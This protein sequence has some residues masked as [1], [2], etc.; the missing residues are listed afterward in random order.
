MRNY[1]I[2]TSIMVCPAKHHKAAHEHHTAGHDE[3][4]AHEAHAARGHQ[5]HAHAAKKHSKKYP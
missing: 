3:K 1:E 2:S 4:A 5:S